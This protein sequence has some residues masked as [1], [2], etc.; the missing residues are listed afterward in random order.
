L[1]KVAEENGAFSMGCLKILRSKGARGPFRAS[2]SNAPPGKFTT[3]TDSLS[4]IILYVKIEGMPRLNQGRSPQDSGERTSGGG[5]GQSN[6]GWGNLNQVL[7][8][9]NNDIGL[10][11]PQREMAPGLSK[12]EQKKKKG[13]GKGTEISIQA[14]KGEGKRG[15]QTISTS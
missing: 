5:K 15:C 8:E 14:K 1:R 9:H 10:W 12:E 6:W 7:S 3:T 13:R 11:S 4:S 2:E